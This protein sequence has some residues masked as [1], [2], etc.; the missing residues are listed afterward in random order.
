[1]SVQLK[2]YN[3]TLFTFQ[4]VIEILVKL[5]EVYFSTIRKTKIQ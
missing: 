5:T 2:F 1:M 4:K 3:S